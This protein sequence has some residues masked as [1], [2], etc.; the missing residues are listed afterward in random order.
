MSEQS[1]LHDVFKNGGALAQAIQ[2]FSE[3]TQ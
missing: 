2:G 3:R 1:K